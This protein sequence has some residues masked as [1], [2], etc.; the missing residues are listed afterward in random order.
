MINNP[1]FFFGD[2]SLILTLASRVPTNPDDSIGG[3]A[4][5]AAGIQTS[6]EVNRFS[7]LN[8][9]L[10]FWDWEWPD[11]REFIRFGQRSSEPFIA[12]PHADD[13]EEYYCY[14]ASPLMGERFDK[15]PTNFPRQFEISI[16]LRSIVGD[17]DVRYWD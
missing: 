11:V 13:S 1:A 17:F 15:E 3:T 10:R 14:L 9:R 8:I 7:I 12:R 4:I 5:S 2:N 6:H 16:A